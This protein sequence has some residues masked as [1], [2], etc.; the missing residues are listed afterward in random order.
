MLGTTIAHYKITAKI[1]QGGMGEVYRATDTKL[2]REV[3]IKVLPQSF[4]EDKER[5]ARFERE[6]KTLAT[7]NHSNI[8][9]IYGLEKSEQSQALVLELVEGEDLSERLKRGPLPVEEALEICKQ[10]AEAL[11]AAHEKGII[12]RDLKPGNIKITED[13]KVKVLDFGLA[14]GMTDGS[15]SLTSANTEDSPTITDAFT[16]PGTI[17]GTAAYM[18]PE[19]A[20]GRN[21]D[22]QTDIWSFGCVL[23]ESLTGK[24]AFHGED[25][26]ETLAS[27]IKGDPDWSLLPDHL[28]PLIHHL[29]IK[30][31]GKKRKQRLHDIAD[32]RIDIERVLTD[33][34]CS[35]K[36]VVTKDEN[37][38]K[39][40]SFAWITCMVALSILITAWVTWNLRPTEKVGDANTTSKQSELLLK[41]DARLFQKFSNPF[42]LSPS[43]SLL[44]YMQAD[45]KVVTKR[46]LYV[47]NLETG[48]TKAIPDTAGIVAPFFSP[49]GDEIGFINGGIRAIP[50]DGGEYRT[51][52]PDGLLIW[53]FNEADWSLDDQIV[54]AERKSNLKLVDASGSKEPRNLTEL[55]KHEVAHLNPKFLD[56]G[57]WVAFC[58]ESD[59]SETSTKHIEV[60]HTQ[61]LERKPLKIDPYERVQYVE[62][63]YL[64][65]TSGSTVYSIPFNLETLQ[66][67][68]ARTIVL[69]G[70]RCKNRALIEIAADGTVVYLKGHDS[71]NT[72]KGLFWL[73]QDLKIEPF[74]SMKGLDWDGFSLSPSQ[75]R[76]VLVADGDLRVMDT[77]Q[78][79]NPTPRPITRDPA[80]DHHPVWAEDEKSIFFY[81]NRPIP[82]GKHGIWNIASDF[83]GKSEPELIFASN[84][85]MFL[86]FQHTKD[87][88]IVQRIDNENTNGIWI[89]NTSKPGAKPELILENRFGES[90]PAISPD[91]KWISY[92]S[93]ETGFG[94]WV[95]PLDHS[96]PTRLVSGTNG[97]TPVWSPDG[98]RLMWRH[99]PYFQYRDWFE[100]GEMG[101]RT[102]TFV[103]EQFSLLGNQLRYAPSTFAFSLDNSRILILAHDAKEVELEWLPSAPPTIL[104]MIT[105]WNPGSIGY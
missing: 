39:R 83:L 43:G 53:N 55:Q 2:D 21:V 40:T 60:V 32:A 19:Q 47:R 84:E 16:K 95:M 42:A 64:I 103:T 10:I 59:A 97:L 28:P 91:G 104:Q 98:S 94:V 38:Q 57:T 13:G 74:T 102:H 24:R 70:V 30:C 88:L 8:A 29:L 85:S 6:A 87:G 89:L 65:G 82:D 31:L 72:L 58:V 25:V 11:E 26:T 73:D 5:L 14:K 90:L 54:Y 17:L 63:G 100:N 45:A 3:A 101:E 44:A 36:N 77:R 7:L 68:G 33:P 52:V 67:I 23:F 37:R 51:I 61:T 69:D 12:H 49:K 41:D 105:H 18:S 71:A 34:F 86:P 62:P 50:N 66:P 15:D 22:Q 48:Y 76:V 92:L 99:G 79:K 1:G 9:G 96:S 56:D 78:G 81:S 4:A 35:E 46:Q 80:D 27:I 93:R 75:E 20:R